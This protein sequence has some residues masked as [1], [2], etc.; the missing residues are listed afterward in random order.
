[1]KNEEFA[2]AQEARSAI[3]NKVFR[4]I[5]NFSFFIFHFSFSVALISC[6]G[7]PREV[8]LKGNFEHL[9][10]GE[11]LIFS[12]DEA[13]DRLDTLL[14]QDGTFSYTLPAIQPATLHILYPNQS[15]LVVF[16]TPGADILI[17][18]DAQNL[19]EVKVSGSEENERYTEFRQDI[20]GKSAAE[21]KS[22][23]RDYILGNPMLSM[24]QYLLT[25]YFLCD[26]ATTVRE[27]T[28]LYDSLCRACP[29]DLA[30]S[31]LATHV[32]AIDQ[33]RVGRPLPDFALTL[34]PGHGGNGEE[35]QIIRR[36]D[37]KGK[38]LLIAFWASWKSGSQSALYRSR[39]LRRELK[40]KG[41]DISLI[42][43]SLDA[44]EKQFTRLEKADSI[45][46]P[47]YCDFLS[48]SSPLVQKW[49]IREL[50]Y[51][52]L[53]TPDG[54]IAAA[55]SDWIKDINDAASKL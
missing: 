34:T 11:F 23:A 48:L 42:S 49:G 7:H 37:Y 47:S 1:M 39:R 21:T 16:A 18:G 35:E 43:Y 40:G 3:G 31:R 6:T 32:R 30:L 55:G 13:L 14:I 50:P 29:E 36:D 9:D 51:F 33:I 52:I 26:T 54:R 24:S 2:T 46:F 22:I 38:L 44:D 5:V 12:T 25:T 28:E 53:V 45:D 4:A 17:K 8:R 41:T 27:A 19:S 20:I 10:Q 15:E